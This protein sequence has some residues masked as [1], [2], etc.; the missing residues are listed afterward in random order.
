MIEAI[1]CLRIAIRSLV[2]TPVVSLLAIAAIA[3]GIGANT[4]VFSIINE[5]MFRMPPCDH[6]EQVR[7]I[8]IRNLKWDVFNYFEDTFCHDYVDRFESLELTGMATPVWATLT[9]YQD[10]L[11]FVGLRVTEGFFPTMGVHPAHG[12]LFSGADYDPAPASVMVLGYRF[13]KEKM[14]G[15]LSV[16]GNTFQVN[17]QI[18]TVIGILPKGFFF[19]GID[20]GIAVPSVLRD[21][22][23]SGLGGDGI[24]G[25]DTRQGRKDSS[26][27]IA[28]TWNS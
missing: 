10:P 25:F 27:G 3:I 9:G 11:R 26:P 2:R 12:R 7:I 13:W 1:Y 21:R 5:V 15:D 6:A 16:L 14:G 4:A 19:M 23:A 28:G 22:T 18:R 8:G 24:T 20:P 17:G